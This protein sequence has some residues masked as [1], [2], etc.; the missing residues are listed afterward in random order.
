MKPSAFGE[1]TKVLD[2][3]ADMKKEDCA[4]LPVFSDGEQVISCWV[5]SFLDRLRFLVYGEMWLNV[6][7][8]RTQPPCYLTTEY[9]FSLPRRIGISRYESRR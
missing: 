2:C 1:V 5:G 7:S 4:Q 8:G 9:P 3:P 6:R